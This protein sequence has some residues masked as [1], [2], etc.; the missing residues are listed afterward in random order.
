M[1]MHETTPQGLLT[2]AIPTYNRHEL[3]KKQI[4]ILLPQINSEVKVVIFD[5]NCNPSVDSYLGELCNDKIKVS[6]NLVNIG[7]DANICRCF[8]Y[9]DTEWLWV[10]S[11][12]DIVTDDA[13][14]IVLN[15]I[16]SNKDSVFINFKSSHEYTT[17]GLTGFCEQKP[18]Y[19]DAFLISIC[20][21]NNSKLRP[22]LIEYYSYLSSMHGQLILVLK[23]LEYNSDGICC[24]MSTPIIRTFTPAEWS[25]IKFI[26]R[27]PIFMSA[28]KGK[29]LGLVK[30]AFADR[31]VFH[32]L[33]FI[34]N[35]RMGKMLSRKDQFLLFIKVIPEFNLKYLLVRSNLKQLLIYIICLF[36]AKPA[37]KML[38]LH[39]ICRSNRQ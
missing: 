23:Y 30:E 4:Q 12:D 33:F 32:I 21:F 27:L 24:F 17:R 10:L 37:S 15:S 16:K 19:S 7:A 38:K 3:L 5:N 29:S 26:E 1:V 9:C 35:L 34:N 14:F 28:F 18:E 39:A 11:D 20:I 8:E 36:S 6:R 31:I 25:K 22:Y 13:I 2:I